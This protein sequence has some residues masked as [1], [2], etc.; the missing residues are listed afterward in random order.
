MGAAGGTTDC[1]GAV[2][3]EE[4]PTA[5]LFFSLEHPVAS[6]RAINNPAAISLFLLAPALYF[7]DAT[8]SLICFMF[9]SPPAAWQLP[10]GEARNSPRR[11]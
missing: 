2:E 11:R 5:G 6:S 3:T 8:K 9:V 4:V 10:Q 7:A 1:A